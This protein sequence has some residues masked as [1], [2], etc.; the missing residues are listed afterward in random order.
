LDR[1]SV[2]KFTVAQFETER[3]MGIAEVLKRRRPGANVSEATD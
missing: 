1:K 3:I 2:R